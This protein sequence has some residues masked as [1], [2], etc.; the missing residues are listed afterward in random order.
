MHTP[1]KRRRRLARTVCLSS[2]QDDSSSAGGSR[3]H[4]SGSG[5]SSS[6]TFQQLNHLREATRASAN[7]NVQQHTTVQQEPSAPSSPC[8]LKAVETPYH[9]VDASQW[10]L[11]L[12]HYKIPMLRFVSPQVVIPLGLTFVLGANIVAG[13]SIK[14]TMEA[15]IPVL[16]G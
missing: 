13:P 15:G 4:H 1:S 10:D 8:K 6:G 3:L 11:D 7:S 16:L 14:V 5:S 12:M 9:P 2:P